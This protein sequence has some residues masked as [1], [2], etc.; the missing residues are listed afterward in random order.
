LYRRVAANPTLWNGSK[1]RIASVTELVSDV[2]F[3]LGVTS[4]RDFIGTN[5][6]LDAKHL[7]QLGYAD[8]SDTQVSS[9]GSV[10]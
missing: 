10:D 6:A 9:F 5:W 1:F 4:Y 7:R 3:N 8:F 2:T